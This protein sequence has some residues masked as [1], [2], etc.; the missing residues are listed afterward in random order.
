[1]IIALISSLVISC[2]EHRPIRN[3]I[4]DEPHYIEKSDLTSPN[5][6]LGDESAD[7]SWLY[8]VNIVRTS[9][10]NITDA[11][12]GSEGPTRLVRFRFRKDAL[13]VLDHMKLQSDDPEDPNDDDPFTEPRVLLEFPGMHVD[14]KLSETLDGERTNYLENNTEAPWAKRQLFQLD[15]E[16]MT[17][18][19]EDTLGT[20]NGYFFKQCAQSV[21]RRLVPDSIV[22]DEE[23]Q[24]LSFEV[25]A[26]Y[27]FD[28]RSATQIC[29]NWIFLGQHT[30]DSN[31]IDTGTIV[32]KFNFYRRG[33]SEY[34]P[35]FI[36]EKDDV[37]E[38]YGVFQILNLFTD[39]DSGF[40]GGE[41]LIKRWNPSRE[42]PVV[43]YFAEGFPEKFKDIFTHETEGVA[44][45]TNAI[46]KEANS[47]MRIE[48]RD[49]DYSEN[50]E[51]IDRKVGDIRYSFVTWFQNLSGNGGLLGYGPSTSDPRTGEVFSANVN[52]YNYA[53]DLFRFLSEVYLEDAGADPSLLEEECTP[54]DTLSPEAGQARCLEDN[55]ACAEDDSCEVVCPETRLKSALF[56]EMRFVMDLGDDRST[57]TA[58]DF[59]PKPQV[60]TFGDDLHRIL[61]EIRYSYPSWNAYVYQSP[62][63]GMV[64]HWEELMASE[65]TF[66]DMMM[67]IT[68]GEN[69][70][71]GIP[72]HTAEGIQMQ[73]DFLQE[74]RLWRTNHRRYTAERQMLKGMRN[75]Y[76]MDPGDFL[77][78]VS[79]SARLC[80]EDRTW[81]DNAEYSDRILKGVIRQLMFHEFGHTIGLRHNFYGTMDSKYMADSHISSS[82]MDYVS[83]QAEAGNSHGWGAYDALALQW[84]YGDEE[85][86]EAALAES[87]LYC[88][89]EHRILS[90]LCQAYDYGTTPAQ[91]VLNAIESYDWNY[92]FRNRRAYRDFWSIGS[93]TNR[94]YSDIFPIQR[95]WYLGLFDWAGGGVQDTLKSLDLVEGKP[96]STP[97]EYD[98]RASDF[99]NN[100]VA[101]NG[102]IMAFYDAVI[103]QA[104]SFRN[105]QTEYD[106][107]YGDIRRVGIIIDKLYATV[108]FMDLQDVY[109]SPNIATYASMYDSP[110]GNE[111]VAL[112]QRVLDNMLGANYDTFPWFRYYALNIF[113]YVAN[114]NL[115]GQAS[116]RDRIAIW[117]YP[118]LADLYEHFPQ[119][120]IETARRSNNPQRIFNHEGEE[121]VYT[122]LEDRRWHLVAGKSRNP[123]SY[124]FIRDYNDSLNDGANTSLDNYGL[125]ILLAYH[126]YYNNF[127]GF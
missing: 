4:K 106:D 93:Y 67:R 107:Y 64:A 87:P 125:K 112:S 37:N 20:I 82:V 34:A 70:F 46:L 42:E 55:A 122:Y 91:I 95:M 101:S 127:V 118:R 7:V 103:N 1:M 62:P 22:W 50:G 32:Y 124:Q 79:K 83:L 26:N 41:R 104:A 29:Y 120:T 116:L 59:I 45:Q 5:P 68:E 97:D 81:E 8:R 9:S 114:T 61:P 76:E 47:S 12:P 38:R 123:V 49:H 6:K 89:D 78:A 44:A 99:F 24:Y 115:V 92:R 65:A 51:V 36:D 69:P 30:F 94:V 88:T 96:L 85:A 102:M 73:N 15:F 35:A 121:Y 48:F 3:G 117:R 100:I 27:M 80:K 113:A 74:F 39:K 16:G 21:S 43:Y 18:D 40:L 84:I 52:A 119:E 90:P 77:D 98:V 17:L 31:V 63:K 72:L 58:Q 108:A 111:N 66:Q 105:F 11:F 86:R 33:P 28:L 53:Y 71:E 13:Q 54:G 2:V 126:E 75:M 10:P 25:E 60:D 23:D 110:I 109:Y 19:V 56:E 14:Q 57:G